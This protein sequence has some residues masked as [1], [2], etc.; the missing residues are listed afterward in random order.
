MAAWNTRDHLVAAS[1]IV[2]GGGPAAKI[3]LPVHPMFT[4]NR[5]YGM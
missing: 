5:A 2:H 1:R 4:D 3:M